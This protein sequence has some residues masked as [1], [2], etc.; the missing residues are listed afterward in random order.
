MSEKISWSFKAQVT[1]GPSITLA[2][3]IE[4]EAYDKIEVP[5]T[6]GGSATAR[7]QPNDS[8]VQFLLL[9]TSDGKYDTLTYEVD[10]SGDIVTFNGPHILIG[11]GAAALLGATQKVFAFNNGGA[12]DVTIGILV[13]RTATS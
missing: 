5:V 10:S 6:A 12:T 13:G 1:A 8:G 4:P 3:T 7:V 9:Y 2:G 11:T